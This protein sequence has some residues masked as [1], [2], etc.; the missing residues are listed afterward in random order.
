MDRVTI[1]GELF[2]SPLWRNDKPFSEFQAYVQFMIWAKEMGNDKHFI[3]GTLVTLKDNEFIMP[4]RK[5]AE[6]INWTQSAVNRFLKKLVTLNQCCINNESKMTRVSLAIV[7]VPQESESILNQKRIN[8]ESLFNTSFGGGTNNDISNNYNNIN[9]NNITT[10]SNTIPNTNIFRKSD[11]KVV[12][13]GKAKPFTAKPKDIQM[14][15][16]YFTEKYP[17]DIHRATHFYEYFE[18][19]GWVTGK[20]KLPIKNWKM[21]V[22]NWMRSQKR[23]DKENNVGGSQGSWVDKFRKSP[24]GEFIVYCQNTKCSR[25]DDSLFMKN[26]FEI[27]QGC[28]CSHPYH[29]Q[30]LNKPKPK[31]VKENY[32]DANEEELITFEEFSKSQRSKK[33]TKRSGTSEGSSEHISDLLGSLFQSR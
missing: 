20:A 15:I 18:T 9:N 23:F 5:I 7:E 24:T 4:Q 27:K 22:A 26:H 12:V 33:P 30:R 1:P 19:V 11:K 13:K 6:S 17:N 10:N 21:A 3:N 29:P 2:D 25:F 8:D 31:P 32:A 14:V 16:D 28:K